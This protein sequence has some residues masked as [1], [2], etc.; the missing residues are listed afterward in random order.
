MSTVDCSKAIERPQELNYQPF[1]FEADRC[2]FLLLTHAHIDHSGL[3]PK[4][5]AGGFDGP[6]YATEATK[7][8]L[9]FMLRDSAYIQE[10]NAERVNRKRE[11]RGE[12]PIVPIYTMPDAEATL[13]QV[14]A[15]E[16]E[17]WFEPKPGVRARF[18]NAGH[19]LGSASVEVQVADGDET[20]KLLF[21]GDLGPEGKGVPSGAG[22][23]H[24]LRL[25]HL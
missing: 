20:I 6:I 23:A 4:L 25:H 24:R 7:D 11:R 21:S 16:Y 1:P 19:L 8:L 22:R 17:T 12:E 3:L 2:E 5:T 18:W 9:E 10:S 15:I 14:R 13:A